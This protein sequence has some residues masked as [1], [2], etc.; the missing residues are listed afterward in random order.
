MANLLHSWNHM[1][2]LSS[3]LRESGLKFWFV[4]FWPSW[5]MGFKIS[6]LLEHTFGQQPLNEG[7]DD[8]WP[9][10]M[11]SMS[12]GAHFM[13][14]K[15]LVHF[16]STIFNKYAWSRAA[17]PSRTQ[18]FLNLFLKS[19]KTVSSIISF[20][21]V[22]FFTIEHSPTTRSFTSQRHQAPSGNIVCQVLSRR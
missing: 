8:F 2:T 16:L 13:S 12:F 21:F 1:T 14:S 6:S 9:S 11:I 7:V 17:P 19:A 22:T 15:R 10:F 4:S 20:P 5:G 18:L 3:S